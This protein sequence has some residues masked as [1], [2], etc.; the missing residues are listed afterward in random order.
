MNFALSGYFKASCMYIVSGSAFALNAKSGLSSKL[1][2]SPFENIALRQKISPSTS[3]DVNALISAVMVSMRRF[4]GCHELF[5]PCWIYFPDGGLLT[6]VL[7]STSGLSSG[8]RGLLLCWIF[9]PPCGVFLSL[10]SRAVRRRLCPWGCS[11]V[12]TTLFLLDLPFYGFEGSL[13]VM[14]PAFICHLA[15]RLS[16]LTVW[17]LVSK[18]R[19]NCGL[20]SPVFLSITSAT[21]Q[22]CCGNQPKQIPTLDL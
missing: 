3:C 7:F 21:I 16:C 17:K 22:A 13:W 18:L 11:P 14:N 2:D 9:A 4:I 20:T 10:P 1:G 12:S 6:C 5:E 15:S 8:S 19:W